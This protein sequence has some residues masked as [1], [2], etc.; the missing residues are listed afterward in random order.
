MKKDYDMI[1]NPIF[2]MNI[3]PRDGSVILAYHKIWEMP[4]CIKYVDKLNGWTDSLH[5]RQ[6][7]E[8]SFLGW[9]ECPKFDI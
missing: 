6:W 9:I 3:A 8:E 7:P 2:E 1:K 4:V 5:T